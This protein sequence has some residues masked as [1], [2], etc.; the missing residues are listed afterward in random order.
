MLNYIMQISYAEFFSNWEVNVKCKDR[1][2]FTP[3]SEE[4]LSLHRLS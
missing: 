1:N 2:S 4:W 3:Q